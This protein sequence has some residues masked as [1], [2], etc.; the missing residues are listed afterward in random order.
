VIAVAEDAGPLTWIGR[1]A[2]GEEG[3]AK[4]DDGDVDAALAEI[5]KGR[6]ERSI[7]S[8]GLTDDGVSGAQSLWGT[9]ASVGDRDLLPHSLPAE[10]CMVRPRSEPLIGSAS[11]S[12]G[13]VYASG[14]A[15][16]VVPRATDRPAGVGTLGECGT[17]GAV[18]PGNWTMALTRQ[19]SSSAACAKVLAWARLPLQVR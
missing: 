18:W 1:R 13:L 14:A 17:A 12:R 5:E 4:L 3:S 16:L 11:C 6:T 7:G 19:R 9:A 8:D 10:S 15:E 2:R